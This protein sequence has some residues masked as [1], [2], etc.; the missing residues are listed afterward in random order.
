[1]KK[2]FYLSG[3]IAVLTVLSINIALSDS[4]GKLGNSGA[5]GEST[6]SQPHCHG[7]GNGNGS[8]GGL[9]DN[10]GPGSIA[11]S[12]SN[13]PGGVYV[14]GTVYHMTVTVTEAGKSLFGFDAVAVD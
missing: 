4:N 3:S 7:A 8:T 9:A 12:C 10:L 11:I 13:M 2:N 5:P 14:P 6:C 1:M